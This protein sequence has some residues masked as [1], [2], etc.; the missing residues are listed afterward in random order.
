VGHPAENQ[1]EFRSST[2][3]ALVTDFLGR[4]FE[5]TCALAVGHLAD[6]AEG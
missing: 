3:G 6:E 4:S 1:W 5:H 2:K